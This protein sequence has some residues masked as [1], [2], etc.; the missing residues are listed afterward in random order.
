MLPLSEQ[1]YIS[2]MYVAG[3]DRAPDYEGYT[4]WQN[5]LAWPAD[6]AAKDQFSSNFTGHPAFTTLY[7][8]LSNNAFVQ[9]IYENVLG[10]AGDAQGIV[11]W[12]TKLQE[13][14]T[15]AEF[16]TAFVETALTVEIN[17]TNFPT[18][19]PAELQAAQQRQDF[20]IN[21]AS[22]GIYFATKLGSASNLS[23]GTDANSLA[24]LNLD[25]AYKASIS[26]L[27]GVT[28]NPATAIAAN[29]SY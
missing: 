20:L 17:S 7:G 19:S 5:Q 27:N 14:M 23:P 26:I 28:N 12:T 24:S 18:L 10:Q 21:K 15:R 11:Y 1:Q 6:Q 22:V 25:P 29:K 4:Y 16:L 3:Y 9:A 13:G 8:G 2:A